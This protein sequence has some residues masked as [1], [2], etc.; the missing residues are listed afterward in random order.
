MDFINGFIEKLLKA[1]EWFFST[2]L[3]YDTAETIF[4][5]VVYATEQFIPLWQEY[6]DVFLGANV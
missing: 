5:S 3:P 4:R 6:I 1:A 2:P